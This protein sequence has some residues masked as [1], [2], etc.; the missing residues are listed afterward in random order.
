MKK[1]LLAI[2]FLAPTLAW[3]AK[4]KPADYTIAVHVQSS[5]LAAVCHD[6]WGMSNPGG[7]GKAAHCGTKQHLKAVID[8][9]KYELDSKDELIGLLLTGD[10]KARMLPDDPQDQDNPIGA[11]E[12]HS[13]YEF[14]FPDGK[15]RKYLVVGESE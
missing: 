12:I 3:A 8:G 6:S 4:P 15:T 1:V 13:T 7:L 5:Q 10:Y 14:L 9:K 11:Y 2:L